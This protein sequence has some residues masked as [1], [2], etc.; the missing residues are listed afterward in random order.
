MR[1]TGSSEQLEARRM[2]AGRLFTLGKTLVEVAEACGVSL[3]AV[4]LWKKAWK[5]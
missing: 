4:K 1:P 3:S 2:I 5:V